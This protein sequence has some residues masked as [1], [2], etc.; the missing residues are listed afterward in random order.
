MPLFYGYS[1]S[2]S[3]LEFIVLKE[4]ARFS[5]FTVCDLVVMCSALFGIIILFYLHSKMHNMIPAY[6]VVVP[7]WKSCDFQTF[8]DTA[9]GF[10]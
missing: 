6:F 7:T 2:L 1:S 8:L 10:L 9:H 5:F 3:I 4:C